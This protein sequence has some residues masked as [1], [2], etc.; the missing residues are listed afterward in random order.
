MIIIIS[1]TTTITGVTAYQS[2]SWI[3]ALQAFPSGL[4]QDL[5]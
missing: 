3:V 1:T 4:L 2:L 5:S